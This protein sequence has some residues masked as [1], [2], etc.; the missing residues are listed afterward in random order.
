MNLVIIWCN[1]INLT[2]NLS[3]LALYWIWT[4]SKSGFRRSCENY[5]LRKCQENGPNFWCTRQAS[6]IKNYCFATLEYFCIAFGYLHHKSLR[7]RE[8]CHA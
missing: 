5:N 7:E 2:L 3:F 1:N 6:V 4:I 8:G